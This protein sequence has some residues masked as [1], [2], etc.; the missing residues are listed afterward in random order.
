MADR[1]MIPLLLVGILFVLAFLHWRLSTEK[2]DIENR[3]ITVSNE[4][5]LAKRQL[6]AEQGRAQ[7]NQ[8]QARQCK[9]DTQNQR[10]E[11]EETLAKKVNELTERM[12]SDRSAG[13]GFQKDL[14]AKQAQLVKVSADLDECRKSVEAKDKE[15]ADFEGTLATCNEE[16]K[17][18]KAEAEKAAKSQKEAEDNLRKVP[19]D[20]PQKAPEATSHHSNEPS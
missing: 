18:A 3:F 1:A 17:K 19:D 6:Q 12:K 5:L 2:H 7:Q 10:K 20:S 8:L 11:L 4:L 15:M 13:E 14:E 9:I 16:M